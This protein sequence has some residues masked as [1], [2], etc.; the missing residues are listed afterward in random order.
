MKMKVLLIPAALMS[1]ALTACGSPAATSGSDSVKKTDSHATEVFDKYNGMSGAER[2]DALIAAAQEEGEVSVYTSN[3][4][5]DVIVD[6]FDEKYGIDVNVYRGNSE[7][8]LQRVLQES[9]AGYAGVDLIETNSGELDILSAE[10]LLYPYES[11]M[12]DAVRPDGQKEFWTADRFNAFVVAWNTD[13]VAPDE[14]PRSLEEFADPKWK[15]KVSMELGDIDWFSSMW[16]YYLQNGKS[17]DDVKAMFEGIASNAKIV[18][19]HTVQAELLSAGE[20]Q[21]GVSM[22]SHS[23]QEGTEEGRPI[24]WRTDAVEPL[25]PIVLRP[26]GGGLVGTA[27][28]PAAALL[29]MDFLLTEGQQAIADEYRIGSVPGRD[30]PLAGLEV[31]SV[32]EEEMLDNADHWDELYAAIVQ[33]GEITEE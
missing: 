26:N 22:Y 23:V 31:I 18:K 17:E 19:G 21:A 15:G 13:L 20:F 1:V 28:H 12:R 27:Q 16:N 25:Q 7:S 14:V 8:V 3:T 30:D 4:D 10:G 9:K 33:G 29:F 2:T 5:L 6:A 11:E 32:D 24:A